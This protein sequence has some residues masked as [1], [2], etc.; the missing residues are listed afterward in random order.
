[1]S[2][3]VLPFASPP[4]PF[5]RVAA[6]SV[7][8]PLEALVEGPVLVSP[9]S[10]LMQHCPIS[11][12]CGVA[13]RV[14]DYAIAHLSRA[15]DDPPLGRPFRHQGPH[16]PLVVRVGAQDDPPWR[17]PYLHRYFSKDSAVGLA[18]SGLHFS[19]VSA[20]ALAEAHLVAAEGG[21]VGHRGEQE[22]QHGGQT[23]SQC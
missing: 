6:S 16:P 12:G 22:P 19:L 13:L 11:R 18:S 10:L 5:H 3:S 9:S 8:P 2:Q 21:H 14:V 20:S 15:Q 4:A 7:C 17:R 23:W 1:M